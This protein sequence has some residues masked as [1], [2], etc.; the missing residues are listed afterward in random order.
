M[1][2]EKR[3]VRVLSRL[4]S[5]VCTHAVASA[6]L[7]T[8]VPSEGAL[9]I[10]RLPARSIASALPNCMPALRVLTLRVDTEAHV[11]SDDCR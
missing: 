11:S 5:V 1:R 7:P 9:T 2:K 8:S 3:I 4:S 6:V 10:S